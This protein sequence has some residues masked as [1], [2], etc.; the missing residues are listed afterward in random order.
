MNNVMKKGIALMALSMALGGGAAYAAPNMMPL[1]E[2]PQAVSATLAAEQIQVTVNGKAASLTGYQASGAQE[3]MLPLRAIAESL[4]FTL[5]WKQ[6]DSSVDLSKGPQWTNVKVGD[7]RYSVNKM[8]KTLGT[9]PEL[10]DNTM[11]V[12]ASFFQEILHA[13][14]T[15]DGNSV[16]VSAAEQK[17]TVLTQGVITAIRDVDGHKAVQINGIGTEGTV[18]TLSDETTYQ[19]A[20]GT[21]LTFADLTLGQKVEAEHSLVATLSL[22]PQ[23]PT[24]KITVLDG[25]DKKGI[26]GT[27][28]NIEE[29]RTSDSGAT[30]LL[31][32]GTGL[33]EQSQKEIVLQ[34]TDQTT[35][36]NLKGEA[37]DKSTLAKGTRV[38]AFYD[39][40]MTKSLPPI[41]KA[42]KIVVQPAAE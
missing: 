41:G 8:L 29:V 25:A 30:S 1:A 5:T 11:Y 42:W 10:K 7:D 38:I 39:A 14:V 16:A 18:L 15:K 34:V 32:K 28:G 3:A 4:G 2:E 17:K 40:M 31:I 27:A 19:K 36:V 13:S 33:N 37:V 6:E 22:P 23:T 35:V 12:P 24:Y 21:P 20:D 9:A 26:L